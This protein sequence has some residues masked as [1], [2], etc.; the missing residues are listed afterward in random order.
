VRVY[1]GTQED[2]PEF[3]K[4]RTADDLLSGRTVGR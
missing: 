2:C 3:R 1:R 4:Y